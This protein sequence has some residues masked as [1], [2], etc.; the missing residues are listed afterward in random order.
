MAA[1]KMDAKR[2]HRI[3]RLCR[4]ADDSMKF[5]AQN[6]GVVAGMHLIGSCD[7][8]TDCSELLALAQDKLAKKLGDAIEDKILATLA[9]LGCLEAVDAP[10][11]SKKGKG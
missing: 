1:S 11:R 9:C 10:S 4:K 2:T 5:L 7:S 8:R 3:A 6:L